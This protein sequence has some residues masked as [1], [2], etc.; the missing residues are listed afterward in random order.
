MGT[1]VYLLMLWGGRISLSLPDDTW[2]LC[3]L[4]SL[5]SQLVLY[6]WMRRR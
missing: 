2:R 6:W 4:L 5:D 1:L 3:V